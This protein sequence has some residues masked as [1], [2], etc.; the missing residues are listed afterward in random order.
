LFA[1]ALTDALIS[2]V[3]ELKAAV[4]IFG[5]DVAGHTPGAQR[6]RRV[7]WPGAR[8]GT[9]FRGGSIAIAGFL[10]SPERMHSPPES[11]GTG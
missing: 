2:S 10:N 4:K 11:R 7:L 6:W 5:A 3:I 1:G 9:M 8:I